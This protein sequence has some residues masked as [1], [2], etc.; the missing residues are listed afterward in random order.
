[1]MHNRPRIPAISPGKYISSISSIAPTASSV[2]TRPMRGR[3]GDRFET[4]QGQRISGGPGQ[5]GA[6]P[7]GPAP[8]AFSGRNPFVLHFLFCTHMR[9]T[10]GRRTVNANAFR[11]L[12]AAGAARRAVLHLGGRVRAERAL[13]PNKRSRQVGPAHEESI[14]FA[15]SPP[16]FIERPDHEALAPAT[17]AGGEDLGN[18][19]LILT[20]IGFHIRTGVA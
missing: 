3:L 8:A 19:G 7:A 15:R 6:R 10:S 11:P 17:I 1:M 13:Q 16:P 2:M 9:A 18:A 5:G 12:N 4:S 14:A 20:V